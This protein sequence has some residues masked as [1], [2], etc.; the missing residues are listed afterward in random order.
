M[1]KKTNTNTN[2]TTTK[3]SQQPPQEDSGGNRKRG[4]PSLAS[5][6][7]NVQDQELELPEED[8][9]LEQDQDQEDELE[10]DPEMKQMYELLGKMK[11]EKLE[12]F[13]VVLSMRM[14]KKE[15]PVIINTVNTITFSVIEDVNLNIGYYNTKSSQE[16]ES[17]FSTPIAVNNNNISYDGTQQPQQHLESIKPVEKYRFLLE[18]KDYNSRTELD[19][20]T[21]SMGARKFPNYVGTEIMEQFHKPLLGKLLGQFE[22]LKTH[23]KYDGD[24]INLRFENFNFLGSTFVMM[25][26]VRYFMD[27][28]TVYMG[29]H[30]G[31]HAKVVVTQTEHPTFKINFI[32]SEKK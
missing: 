26:I 8:G 30:N 14:N 19:R 10:L 27:S 15:T 28:G 2:T 9:L 16:L 17:L 1:I 6:S 23:I 3:R 31:S 24:E 13:N 7:K 21:K 4:R 32:K 20:L 18:Y 5:S 25:A 11:P 29:R 12:K 22:E